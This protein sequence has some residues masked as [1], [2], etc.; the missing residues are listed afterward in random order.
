MTPRS[1]R[2]ASKRRRRSS[3]R[4]KRR[5]PRQGPRTRFPRGARLVP[6]PPSCP[7]QR[8]IDTS[9]PPMRRATAGREMR[10][11]CQLRAYKG[12]RLRFVCIQGG[13]SHEDQRHQERNRCR[14]RH[15]GK[16]D[17][18]PDCLQGLCRDG[19]G[20][21]R[22]LSRARP[23]PLCHHQEAVPLHAG[24]HEGRRLRLLPR[25]GRHA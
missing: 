24:G 23:R 11:F 21:Q 16:P 14:R 8:G 2:R 3:R 25:P 18:V 22:G 17:C 6:L 5:H 19:V 15:P 10:A 12:S 9:T 4:T 1:I 7:C 13:E 20:P